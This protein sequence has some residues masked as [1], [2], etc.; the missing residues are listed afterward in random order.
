MQAPFAA[1]SRSAHN[2][3]RLVSVLAA[4]LWVVGCGEPQ[5]P[6]A[7]GSIPGLTVEVGNTESVDLAGYFSDPDGDALGYAAASADEG[8]ATVGVTGATLRVE[9]VGQGA[10]TV[11]VTAADPGGLSA[12][13]EFT[14]TVPNRGPEAA[15]EM[16]DAEVFVGEFV[17]VELAGYFSDPDGDALTY[18]AASSN[19]GAVT[20]AVAGD[21]LR[22]EGVGRETVGVT[23]TATD[24][25]E[26]SATQSFEVTVHSAPAYLVQAVQ[27]WDIQVPV[28]A[29]K[30]ALLRVFVRA[31]RRTTEDPASGEGDLLRRRLPETYSVEIDGTSETIPTEVYEG[32][33]AKSLNVAIPAS[34]D[35]GG[36]V[37]RDRH[38]P[39]LDD[40]RRHPRLQAD[41]EERRAGPGGGGRARVRTHRHSVPVHRGSRFVGAGPCRR[42]GI[43][44]G[45]ARTPPRH[46]RSDSDR[47]DE[48]R[49]PRPRRDRHRE[50]VPRADLDPCDSGRR[51]R[52]GILDGHYSYR[53]SRWLRRVARHLFGLHPARQG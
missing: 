50:L 8:V 29:G 39:R 40:R 16:T 34:G 47:G 5:P 46:L 22:V 42:H 9:G 17:E 25:G 41:P 51:E 7:M 2:D 12:E 1:M 52:I 38:R 20:V 15:G 37:G 10:A 6:V 21:T 27:S 24:P 44:G 28:V 26:L 13:Q 14:V 23:V 32:S 45:G 3:F 53:E 43:G 18:A 30:E 33:L 31:T 36:S 48:R 4:A 11:T 35:R 19:E 49:G